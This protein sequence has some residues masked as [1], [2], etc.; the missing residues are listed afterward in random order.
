M[1]VEIPLLIL[2]SLVIFSYI[3]DLFARKTKIPSI[4]L[5]LAT[6][7]GLQ[8]AAAYFGFSTVTLQRILPL[9]GTIG[10]ILIVLEGSLELKLTSDKKKLLKQ[11]LAASFFILLGTT[12]AI[13]LLFYYLTES[14]L[15]NAFINAIPFS[16]ISSAIAIPSASSLPAARKEF[17]VYESSL[18]DIFGIMLFNFAITNTNYGFISFSKLI[19]ETVVITIL[20]ATFCIALLYLLSRITHRLK[21]FLV[22]SVLVLVYA[23]GKFYH[24][25][26][27]V[28]VLVFG[29]FL[30]NATAIRSTFFRR[31]FLYKNYD[32][33]LEQL[34][35]LSGESAFLV[36][37][38]FFLIFGLS[39]DLTSLANVQ[40]FLAGILI[41]VLI[42]L[43]R[44]FY[45]RI[46]LKSATV[47]ELLLSPRGLI[48]ILL[49]M[50]IP[51]DQRIIEVSEGVMLLVILLTS[52]IMTIGLLRAKPVDANP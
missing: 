26:S 32:Q 51:E 50:S 45:Q 44:F 25:S 8:F 1:K 34:H 13:T 10:L 11:S 4:L 12:F 7:V 39:L 21:F 5:L 41:A 38:F 43:V 9:M 33:D 28:I 15:R 35:L 47:T 36:R 3:F 31:F 17:V 46:W 37:T 27:L 48:S 16:I 2:S 40:V 24:L 30:S 23:F 19:G 20:S 52:L 14:S 6:G 22:I 49:F 42:Y 29:L 18:S